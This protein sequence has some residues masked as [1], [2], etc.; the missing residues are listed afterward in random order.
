MLVRFVMP[1][2]ASFQYLFSL[3][4]IIILYQ[5][6]LQIQN[7]YLFMNVCTCVSEFAFEVFAIS[8]HIVK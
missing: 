8:L 5:N 4:N 7:L 1:G 6:I 2:Q 3:F